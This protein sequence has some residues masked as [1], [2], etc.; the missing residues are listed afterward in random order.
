VQSLFPDMSELAS[1]AR[2]AEG[3]L[4]SATGAPATQHSRWQAAQP[5]ANLPPVFPPTLGGW[6]EN[7]VH[8]D[9]G[10]QEAESDSDDELPAIK[11]QVRSFDPVNQRQARAKSGSTRGKDSAKAF[12]DTP[13]LKDLLSPFP[14]LESLVSRPHAKE[15]GG[16]RHS[17][18]GTPPSAS[19]P[20]QV[21]LRRE[22]MRPPSNL[23]QLYEADDFVSPEDRAAGI[24]RWAPPSP[25]L[26]QPGQFMAQARRRY[27]RE[28]SMELEDVDKA[29][30]SASDAGVASLSP[31]QR[32]KSKQEGLEE[33]SPRPKKMPFITTE[34]DKPIPKG[35]AKWKFLGR[36]PAHILKMK[37]PQD[38]AKMLRLH[39]YAER[40]RTNL[41]SG[42][43]WDDAKAKWMGW[44]KKNKK[45]RFD[46]IEMSTSPK[47]ED[48]EADYEDRTERRLKREARF[49]KPSGHEGG[50]ASASSESRDEGSMPEWAGKGS[51]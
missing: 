33:L 20:Y 10:V 46:K 7:E 29:R 27:E 1:L 30:A 50:R 40:R 28:W 26:A 47:K 12:K 2:A 13:G 6:A 32:R 36:P 11:P 15:K 23:D 44:Y 37:K 31:T 48:V 9:E 18:G 21:G 41:G 4:S 45:S 43:D 22:W 8:P 3:K 5:E 38:P 24:R 14:G 51:H 34:G 42:L 25:T 19:N 16:A 49:A 39:R 35:H 17:S